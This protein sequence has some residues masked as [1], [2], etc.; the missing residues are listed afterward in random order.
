MIRK[1]VCSFNR[2]IAQLLILL[3]LF[4]VDLAYSSHG[5]DL[6][7][8]YLHKIADQT[9][10]TCESF[11]YHFNLHIPEPVKKP[12]TFLGYASGLIPLTK[13]FQDP[14]KIFYV[15]FE[16]PLIGFVTTPV[17]VIVA[18]MLTGHGVHFD[19]AFVNDSWE[20]YWTYQVANV[21]RNGVSLDTSLSGNA[22]VWLNWWF[23]ASITALG[24]A[25]GHLAHAT[26]QEALEHAYSL[27]AYSMSFPV[28]SQQIS[29]R[30]FVPLFFSKFP[31]K[32]VLDQVKD[33]L[34]TTPE[35]IAG[36]EVIIQDAEA[37]IKRLKADHTEASHHQ[38]EMRRLEEMLLSARFS[39]KW[40][41]WFREGYAD[42]MHLSKKRELQYWSIKTGVTMSV[43]VFMVA[44][45]YIGR[46]ELIGKAPED[47]GA[48]KA[49]VKV[50]MKELSS[51]SEKVTGEPSFR[52]MAEEEWD[53]AVAAVKQLLKEYQEGH[54]W[55]DSP[56]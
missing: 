47:D 38:G 8:S 10:E 35:L 51:Q 1:G 52:Q 45:F 6:R 29:Q 12:L 2:R 16:S 48:L 56:S 26:N 7:V 24:T 23:S 20:I 31:K 17:S 25:G 34:K 4:R 14:D 9:S 30:F 3:N 5:Q 50:A 55:V 19:W 39:K 11:F 22:R 28:F 40:I 21:I 27:I 18:N 41:Q 42:G 15:L 43:A 46:W 36:Q 54:L 13:T 32:S 37:E 44:L 49:M 33:P 53:D